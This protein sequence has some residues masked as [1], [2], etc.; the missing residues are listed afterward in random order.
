MNKIDKNFIGLIIL[1]ALFILA[2]AGL[3]WMKSLSWAKMPSDLPELLTGASK[4]KASSIRAIKSL[5]LKALQNSELNGLVE[6][7]VPSTTPELGNRNPFTKPQK[8]L[9]DQHD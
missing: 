5:N 8:P 9:N 2:G 7:A 1:I 4:A 6:T 3:F